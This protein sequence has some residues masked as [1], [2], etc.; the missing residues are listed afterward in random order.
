MYYCAMIFRLFPE[1]MQFPDPALAEEDGL[2]AIGGD[3]S[4][5]R[6]ELAYHMGIF[7]WY[8]EGE[9]I[10]WYAP[11]ERCVIFPGKIKVSKSMQQVFRKGVFTF[12]C[13]RA[14]ELVIQHCASVP[15]KGQDGTW[16]TR[17][18]QEAYIGLHHA[19]IA[20]SIE[21]WQAGFLAGGLYGVVINGVFCGESMFSLAANASKAALI[22]MCREQNYRLIDCQVP[23]PHLMSLGA[24][25]ISRD[26]YL[27]ILNTQQDIV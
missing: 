12:S 15:R 1:I 22:W 11:H 6:L 9:P 8:S 27:R 2:L 25:L 16:I 23:N 10:L 20:H 7:P 21:V 5:Q 24:E 19:G 18:M 14:F 4:R 26:R 13:D 17:E 3:L